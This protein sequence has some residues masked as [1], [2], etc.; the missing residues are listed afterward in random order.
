MRGTRAAS[1]GRLGGGPM[2]HAL[3]T[4]AEAGAIEVADAVGDYV[5]DVDGKRYLPR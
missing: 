3:A 2:T 1:E 4:Q 5:T